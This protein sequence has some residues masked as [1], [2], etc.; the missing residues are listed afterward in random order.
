MNSQFH[1]V[2]C[3][4]LLKAASSWPGGGCI[5]KE[6]ALG[7]KQASSWHCI[8][9]GRIR[10]PTAMVHAMHAASAAAAGVDAAQSDA[11]IICHSCMN[12]VQTAE[13]MQP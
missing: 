6:I 7:S 11:L 1:F 3:S 12:V 10:L 5:A 2:V 13:S 8:S 4:V 9:A